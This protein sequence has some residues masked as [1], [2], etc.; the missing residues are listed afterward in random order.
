[1]PTYVERLRDAIEHTER[2]ARAKGERG[3]LPTIQL[4]WSSASSILT[5]LERAE[6]IEAAATELLEHFDRD[7]FSALWRMNADTL[8]KRLRF[9]LALP[10]G[11]P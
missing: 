4:D 5:A 3:V 11:T 6:R 1:M 2:C 7:Q 8:A 9:A 10:G